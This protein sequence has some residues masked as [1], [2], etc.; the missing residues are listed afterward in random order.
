MNTVGGVHVNTG[1]DAPETQVC[2]SSALEHGRDTSPQAHGAWLVQVIVINGLVFGTLR[3][4]GWL[5]VSDIDEEQGLDG[6]YTIGSGST[7]MDQ[8]NLR[9]LP[10]K[11]WLRALFHR[12]EMSPGSP[13]SPR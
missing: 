3:C 8:M 10:S 4:L 7:L 1:L 9:D 13:M 6:I 5:R 11:G 2:F 12:P